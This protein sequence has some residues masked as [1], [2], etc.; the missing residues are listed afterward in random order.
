MDMAAKNATAGNID[1]REVFSNA[2]AVFFI[3]PSI[4]G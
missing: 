1:Q 2:L 3:A 4:V